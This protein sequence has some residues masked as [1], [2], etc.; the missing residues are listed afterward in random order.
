MIIFNGFSPIVNRFHSRS[1]RFICFFYV[2]MCSI[3]KVLSMFR[4]ECS[5]NS[6]ISNIRINDNVIW[7]NS[8]FHI[9]NLFHI[10][11]IIVNRYVCHIAPCSQ[12]QNSNTDKACYPFSFF[13]CH[14]KGKSK[15]INSCHSK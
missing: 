11:F 13:L 6:T 3:D 9:F 7:L 5:Y 10:A 14:E 4:K 12:C 1:I 2:P 8:F 15:K